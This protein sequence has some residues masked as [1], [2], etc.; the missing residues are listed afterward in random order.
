MLATSARVAGRFAVRFAGALASCWIA[1]LV[2][3]RHGD[4]M[5]AGIGLEQTAPQSA[6]QAGPSSPRSNEVNLRPGQVWSKPSG[7]AASERASGPLRSCLRADSMRTSCRAS[8]I[9]RLALCASLASPRIRA[10][11]AGRSS[12]GT[13][14]LGAPSITARLAS[15]RAQEPG[16]EKPAAAVGSRKCE[17]GGSVCCRSRCGSFPSNRVLD[18]CDFSDSFLPAAAII[19]GAS[20]FRRAPIPRE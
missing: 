16:A 1:A 15:Y 6:V 8:S 14:R 20:M 10:R 9:L 7:I 18:K 5:V 2:K 4:A 11:R 13:H 12:L 19:P 3:L 17:A